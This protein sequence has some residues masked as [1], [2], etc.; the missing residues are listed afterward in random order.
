MGDLHVSNW[1][2]WCGARLQASRSD[3]PRRDSMPQR[4]E[5]LLVLWQLP[6]PLREL[7]SSILALAAILMISP[8]AG[9]RPSRAGNS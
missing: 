1:W 4:R 8:V 5:R 7:E 3:P 6:G 2:R 9:F